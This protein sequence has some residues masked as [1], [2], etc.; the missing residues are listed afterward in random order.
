MGIFDVPAA[1][2]IEAVSTDLK[3]KL[4]E[5]GF[6]D[7]VKTGAHAERTPD[8]KDWFYVRSASVLYRVY[9]NG[10]GGT[11]RLR[12]YYGGRKNRGVKP[13]KKRKASG[14]VIRTCLQ[15]LEKAGLLKKAKSGRVVTGKGE[16]LLFDKARIIEKDFKEEVA[17]TQKDKAERVEKAATRKAERQKKAEEAK[18]AREQKIAEEKK[19]QELELAKQEA[20]KQAEDKGGAN[21]R[22][23]TEAKKA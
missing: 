16:K 2:L 3:Q 18:R 7:Y 19:A 17:K 22:G 15:E 10:N 12:T 1:R 6:V 23:G 5:P 20:A 13:E 9:K 21:E 14:K 11:G 8:R 4:K